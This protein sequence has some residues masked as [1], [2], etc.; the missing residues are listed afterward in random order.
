[1]SAVC[2]SFW[3]AQFS[4]I[5]TAKQPTINP[6][7]FSTIFATILTTL[8]TA[9]HPAHGYPKLSTD[10]ATVNPADR[11]TQWSAHTAAYCSTNI[12]A[13]WSAK[14]STE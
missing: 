1:M 11:T 10:F 6:T 7:I 12:F 4:A 8:F 2:G 14:W 5:C 13:K 3:S 9:I